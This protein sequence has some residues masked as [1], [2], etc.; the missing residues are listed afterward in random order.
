VQLTPKQCQYSKSTYIVTI[1]PNKLWF[2]AGR[3]MLEGNMPT[4]NAEMVLVCGGECWM[5]RNGRYNYV[6]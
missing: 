2:Y 4:M 1:A 6:D 3:K 5:K